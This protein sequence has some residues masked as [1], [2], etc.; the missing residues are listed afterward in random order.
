LREQ[1]AAWHEYVN[2]KQ[3]AVD[4]Q[5]RSDARTKLKTLGPT[6]KT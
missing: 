4:W 3:R 6:I 2:N 1:T 5:F